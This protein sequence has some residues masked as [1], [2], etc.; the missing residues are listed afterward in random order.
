MKSRFYYWGPLLISFKISDQHL[1]EVKKLCSKKN[2]HVNPTLVGVIKNEHRVDHEKYQ[3][4]IKKYLTGYEETYVRIREEKMG[5]LRCSSSW[6]N[7]MKQHEYN[8]PHT[9]SNCEVSSVLFVSIP[10]KLKKENEKWKKS[11]VNYGGPGSISF[12]YGTPHKYNIECHE[13]F[14]EEGQLLLF[15]KDLKHF[16][17]PFFSK[18]ERI[19]IAA[20]FVVD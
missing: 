14:P 19:S 11:N 18:C 7:Y 20:N 9:H 8:P 10:E 1:N 3:E 16:V 12:F 2:E 17:S 4:I 5:A 15:P 6:V 13:F